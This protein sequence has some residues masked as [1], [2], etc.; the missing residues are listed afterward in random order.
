MY[1]FKKLSEAQSNLVKELYSHGNLIE[2]KK[3]IF[4]YNV[5]VGCNSC[6]Y[7][8]SDAIRALKKQLL[9]ESKGKEI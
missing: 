7:N 8:Q 2:L 6:T 4:R 5:M 9:N 3:R 1:D